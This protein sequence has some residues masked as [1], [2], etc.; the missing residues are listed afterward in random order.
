M[1]LFQA[2]PGEHAYPEWHH[3]PLRLT[4]EE[5]VN[6][7]L[8]L[9]DF[10]N[11]CT[12]EESR[13]HLH[14]WLY[15]SFYDPERENGCFM[16]VYEQT[17]RLI[18][19]C[20]VIMEN[21]RPAG[22]GKE[23]QAEKPGRLPDPVN[24]TSECLYE[25]FRRYTPGSLRAEW[26]SWYTSVFSQ[27]QDRENE[28]GPPAVLRDLYAI[29]P[30]LIEALYLESKI[31]KNGMQGARNGKPMDILLLTGSEITA[32][33]R[34]INRFCNH[35]TLPDVRETLWYMLDVLIGTGFKETDGRNPLAFYDCASCLV[36]IAY[37]F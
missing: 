17:E 21:K 36:E 7:Y 15:A 25:I 26:A 32:P 14:E 23:D 24:N 8:V 22:N 33:I 2:E 9:A 29:F 19:A 37:L 6:P 4:T 35:F 13:N 28:N 5:L 30:Y 1:K 12:L 10:F 16:Y 27:Q 11:F 3:R 34:V 31:W 20:W 18:E